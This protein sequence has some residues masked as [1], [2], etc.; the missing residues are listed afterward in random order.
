MGITILVV[1]ALMII[2]ASAFYFVEL[3]PRIDV[4]VSIARAF[5]HFDDCDAL[6]LDLADG[7]QILL[8][9]RSETALSGVVYSEGAAYNGLEFG[10]LDEGIWINMPEVSEKYYLLPWSDDT[11]DILDEG[12]IAEILNFSDDDKE[13]VADTLISL[14]E[15]LL[16]EDNYD[17]TPAFLNRLL[18]LD[19]LKAD[20]LDIYKHIDFEDE[21]KESITVDGE[22]VLCHKYTAEFSE[23][24]VKLL[25]KTDGAGN[26]LNALGDILGETYA[27]AYVSDGEL[28]YLKIETTF[29]YM[30][31]MDMS[32]LMSGNVS[33]ENISYSPAPLSGEIYFDADG[34][35][36]IYAELSNDYISLSADFVLAPQ[37]TDITW[38][39]DEENELNVFSAGYLRLLL[40]AAKWQEAFG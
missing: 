33:A 4:A 36:N 1:L 5:E 37:N 25:L 23:E 2:A 28:I 17:F 3:K 29:L 13:K 12:A 24:Y 10:Y 35:M 27:E 20:I 34:E 9:I 18:G 7:Q 40:E 31:D 38:G 26:V 39:F 30:P 15:E 11:A 16:T 32:T 21:G 8:D 22:S 6:E 14:R 19:C